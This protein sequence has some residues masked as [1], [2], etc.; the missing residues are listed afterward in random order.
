MF[1][2]NLNA[3]T[4]L[5]TCL[6]CVVSIMGL[7]SLALADPGGSPGHS[8]SVVLLDQDERPL[9]GL[10]VTY[11]NQA[12]E[13][14]QA[15]YTENGTYTLVDAPSKVMLTIISKRPGLPVMEFALPVSPDGKP[16]VALMLNHQTGEFAVVSMEK[17]SAGTTS[18][19]ADAVRYET[20]VRATLLNP[21]A[22]SKEDLARATARPTPEPAQ[23]LGLGAAPAPRGPG[24]DDCASA[25]AISGT[26][27]FAFNNTA[28]TTD[29]PTHGACLFF[30]QAGITNDV[31]F[32]WTAS[33]DA[34]VTIETCGQTGMDSK[35][36]VYDGCECPVDDA[37]LLACNDDAC[38]LQSRVVFTAVSGNTYLIRLG[39]FPGATGGTGT[40]SIS[41]AGGGGGG[42]SNCCF[43]H[44][45]PGC[46]DP[47][48]E[49]AVCACDSFC[50][51]VEW[52]SFCA[53]TG[54]FAG[55]G[56]EILCSDLCGGGGGGG[57][58]G[59]DD[60]DD[61]EKIT[62]EGLFNFNNAGM[63]KD[64]VPDGLCLAFGQD[65]ITNDVWFCWNSTCDGIVRVET[66][67]LTAVDTKIAVYEADE[68]CGP[69]PTGLGIL[70]CND[71]S[72]ALQ[73]RVEFTAVN[74][75][76]YLIRLGTFPG[77]SGGSGQFRIQCQGPPPEPVCFEPP[78]NCH[79]RNL[80]NAFNSNRTNFFAADDFTPA[81][82]GSVTGLCWWGT[83][84]DGFGDCQGVGPDTFIVRYYTDV[85]NL[86]G[87]VI[88]TFSQSGGT[89]AVSGPV[90]TGGL[91]AG[92]VPEYEYSATH[93]PVPVSAGQCYWVEISN[94]IAG[95]S[96]F[97]E[98]DTV[99]TGNER[100]V[101]DDPSGTPNGY[102]PE[103]VVPNNDAAFCLNLALGNEAS[104]G[105]PPATNDNC[106]DAIHITKGGTFPFDNS[107]AT[108]DGLSHAGCLEFG[109]PGIDNDVWFLWRAH[110]CAGLVEVT[111]CGLTSVDTKIAVYDGQPYDG[112]AC[113]PG[114][115]RLLACND[116][117]CGL[118]TRV[119]FTAEDNHKYLIRIGTFPGASGGVGAFTI[120]CLGVAPEACTLDDTAGHCHTRNNANAFN[121]NRTDF[122]AADDFTPAADG[123]VTS[124]CWWGTYFD[125]FGDCQGVAP[126]TFRVCYYDD[127]G[128]LPGNLIACFSQT[129]ATLTVTGPIDTLNLIAGFVPEYE[130]SATH[131]PVAVQAGECYW[132]EISNQISGCSWFWEIDTV[133]SGNERM[134]QDGPPPNGYDPGDVVPNNDAAFCINLLMGNEALCLP[135]PAANDDCANADPISGKGLFAFDNSAAT[136]DGP[137]GHS[138]C[139]QFGLTG[140][141]NDVWFC[142][143]A[144]STDTVQVDTCGLTSVDTKIAVY[145]GCACPVDDARLLACNDD[146]CGLQSSLQ[147]S[148]VANQQYLI[149]VGTFPGAAGGVGQFRIQN[150][151]TPAND[152]CQNAIG[153]LAVPSSTPGS[154]SFATVDSSFPFCG[155]SITAPGVWYTVVGT[156]N[157]MTATTCNAFF[158][159]DTKISVYCGSCTSPICI[160]GNDDL[161]SGGASGLL[162]TVTWCSESGSTYL[163]LV[164]GFSSA[165]GDF[166]LDV[167]DTTPCGSPIPCGGGG[168][169]TGSDSCATPDTLSGL[170][171]FPFNN[172]GMTT[173]GV[174][175][176]LCLQFGQDNM[177]NDVWFCWTSACSGTVQ[178]DTCGQTSVDTKIAVYDGCSPCPT[179]NGILACNDDTCSLQSS[180]QFSAVNGQSYLIRLGTW[181]FAA[182][183]V[184]TF[185]ISSVSCLRTVGFAANVPNTVLTV[186]STERGVETT[187]APFERSF[188]DGSTITVTAP[189]Q[190][191]GRSFRGWKINGVSMYLG[192][193]TI[194]LTVAE[195][196][197]VE[198]TYQSPVA[199]PVGRPASPSTGLVGTVE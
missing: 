73:S 34:E 110:E 102:G 94:Q 58:G 112:M 196:M 154:T 157:T 98:I 19:K 173:D 16:V 141:D 169:A 101:Q 44:P 160:G 186:Q 72:C 85:G 30:G 142:W 139:L 68:N 104:C 70:A 96:W 66:C 12:G 49:A 163:I 135:P 24:A 88:A 95:C 55:C 50:C 74:G 4:W 125:G 124:L 105:P 14:V 25:S 46:D 111:T 166:I 187:V 120:T 71:D 61:A 192:Q 82:N 51:D 10:R 158:G 17:L 161:C 65:N 132:V 108:T 159:Y 178:I 43:A 52:D 45:S 26:G 193:Q 164:H 189:A 151:N 115:D 92:F 69:C 128:G 20:G 122:L 31:W 7:T 130:Y 162:S 150:I 86:P 38:A 197:T 116:D 119:R 8:F 83:Y 35:L 113:P 195:D 22:T 129:A 63:T 126:D 23:L 78:Q 156:G 152:L 179:A 28:A 15:A 109:L 103:D 144:T 147:F 176:P 134:V 181:P 117:A 64:G 57:E 199:P 99:A 177:A 190:V 5:V 47:A 56:A 143:T 172:A 53:G 32:C 29:G 75:G 21:G 198:A 77:A 185:T 191:N 184:G 175:D 80:D 174:A 121:S 60:C 171:T 11:V 2:K 149:R 183:G 168:G 136:T 89:L 27:S 127:N 148:A 138:A 153:P 155:T 167:F 18:P 33:C 165:S 1:S 145:D 62:G 146:V 9:G 39:N 3:S 54:F 76:Q 118:Q 48:C 41:C 140:L 87:A 114:D 170:G 100:M 37:R 133:G 91:I 180:V 79:S 40:F 131:A 106:V 42:D 107:S 6:C 13:T 93:A 194:Q 97:W 90:A 84:F 67:G 188:E 182:G 123:S 59:E 137:Q 81:A 36:A